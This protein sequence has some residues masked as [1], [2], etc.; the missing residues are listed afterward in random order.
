MSYRRTHNQYQTPK[1]EEKSPIK[2]SEETLTLLIDTEDTRDSLKSDTTFYL[3]PSQLNMLKTISNDQFSSVTIRNTPLDEITPN[4]LL[5]IFSKVNT[6]GK[7]EI[8]VYQPLEVMQEIDAKQIEAC[9]LLVGFIDTKITDFSYVDKNN[10]KINTLCV[11]FVKPK[12]RVVY[13]NDNI[14][15]GN[16]SVASEKEVVSGSNSNTD[17][18]S[19]NN[20]SSYRRRK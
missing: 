18:G 1:K 10:K 8:I 13:D 12:K 20:R 16:V 5:N 19:K 15:S 14:L 7:V 6:F 11:S 3:H 4:S 17:S 2:T 9:A